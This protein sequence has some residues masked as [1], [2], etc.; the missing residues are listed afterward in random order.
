MRRKYEHRRSVLRNYKL[1]GRLKCSV[2]RQVHTIYV[3]V[4]SKGRRAYERKSSTASVYI[5]KILFL[6]NV[7]YHYY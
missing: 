4:T 6:R 2:N 7:Y 1:W 5:R 3:R